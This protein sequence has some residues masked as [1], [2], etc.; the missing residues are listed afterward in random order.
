M[1]QNHSNAC[2]GSNRKLCGAL[3]LRTRPP[4]APSPS[5]SLSLGKRSVTS[6]ELGTLYRT[7]PRASSPWRRTTASGRLL[8][9]P[10]ATHT[11]WCCAGLPRRP[12]SRSVRSS[13]WCGWALVETAARSCR[14]RPRRRSTIRPNRGAC[15]SGWS[16]ADRRSPAGCYETCP[17]LCQWPEGNPA[18]II[19][20]A[21]QIVRNAGR[22]KH[23]YQ[24]INTFC[25][26]W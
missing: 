6:L 26:I 18:D 7:W 3:V 15:W 14:T 19:R 25:K 8:A 12:A 21:L 4:S 13:G 16:G 9:P 11:W 22:T 23:Q 1:S 24:R 2:S 20:D 10:A 17:Y 5:P